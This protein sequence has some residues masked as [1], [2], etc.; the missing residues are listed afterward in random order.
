MQ[1]VILYV[2]GGIE[3][4][5]P[6]SVLQLSATLYNVWRDSRASR[7]EVPINAPPAAIRACIDFMGLLVNH[8]EEQKASPDD[9]LRTEPPNLAAWEK[10][11]VW[12]VMALNDASAAAVTAA[13]QTP[14]VG[15][16]CEYMA[17]AQTLSAIADYLCVPRLQDL[18]AAV[19]AYPI[20]RVAVTATSVDAAEARIREMFGAED[21]MTADKRT[22]VRA[23]FAWAYMRPETPRIAVP[24]VRV[25]NAA[26]SASASEDMQ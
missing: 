20:E 26:A 9:T 3:I 5:V 7:L 25:E 11:W 12:T 22:E 15:V 1:Q 24:W 6:P 13:G 17:R 21:D 16:L 8:P 10:Q 23:Q 14:D 18:L 19:E 2:G 4:P